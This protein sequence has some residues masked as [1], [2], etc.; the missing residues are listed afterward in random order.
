MNKRVLASRALRGAA[1]GAAATV[2]LVASAEAQLREAIS[3][4]QQTSSESAASQGRIDDIDTQTEALV[5]EYRATLKQLDR[6]QRYN[7]QQRALIQSQEEEMARLREDIDS[8]ANIQRD[9]VPLMQDMYSALSQFVQA[10]V[11]FLQEE[12][13]ERL[14]RLETIL[15][16]AAADNAEKYRRLMEAFEIENEYGR[17]IEAYRGTLGSG[18]EAREVEFLRIGRNALMFMTLDEAELGVWDQR[19]R[20]WA[21]LDSGYRQTIRTGL[22]MAREQIPPN[23]LTIPVQ[24]PLDAR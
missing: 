13:A 4:S 12:R 16:S 7:E 18:E 19:A 9:V 14:A 21:P 6:L 20:A 3:T 1:L 24:A 8:V 5:R 11:P 22:R 15:A 17:T 10:D 2:A 23:L